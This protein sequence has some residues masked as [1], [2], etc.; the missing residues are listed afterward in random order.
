M[1]RKQPPDMMEPVRAPPPPPSISH[2]VE[3]RLRSSSKETWEREEIAWLQASE[4]ACA[5]AD[6]WVS[7]INKSVLTYT[8][9]ALRVSVPEDLFSALSRLELVTRPSAMRKVRP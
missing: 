2:E 4:I 6:A 7:T 5:V 8:T 9:K 3:K 1:K